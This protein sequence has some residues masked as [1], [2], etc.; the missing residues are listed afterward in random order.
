MWRKGQEGVWN[1][2]PLPITDSLLS[3]VHGSLLKASEAKQNSGAEYPDSLCDV[4]KDYVMGDTAC[5][6]CLVLELPS[7]N[8]G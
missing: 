4:G 2:I 5:S 8:E 3:M 1:R 7:P 6:A